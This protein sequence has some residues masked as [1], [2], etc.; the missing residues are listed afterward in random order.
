MKNEIE[1]ILR[2]AKADTGASLVYAEILLSL[3]DKNYKVDDLGYWILKIERDDYE[4]ILSFMQSVSNNHS[5][6]YEFEKLVQPHIEDLKKIA[7]KF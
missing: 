2:I 1:K 3:L 5:K 6:F 4:F 7:S